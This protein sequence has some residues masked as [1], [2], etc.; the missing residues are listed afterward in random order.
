MKDS[1]SQVD[2][3][4]HKYEREW[5]AWPVKDDRPR[6]RWTSLSNE[7]ITI[8]GLT[9][10]EREAF[11]AFL[12]GASYIRCVDG[13]LHAYHSWLP[14]PNAVHDPICGPHWEATA[15]PKQFGGIPASEG[16]H[17]PGLI[18]TGLE[19]G[20]QK[21]VEAC[22]FVCLRSRRALDGKYWEQWVLHFMDAAKGPLEQH[23]REHAKLSW[24]EK[25][26]EA[27]RFLAIDLRVRFGSLDITIQRWALACP[28]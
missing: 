24:H 4:E 20:M 16:W 5:L 21:L 23:M 15:E 10:K 18:L 25:A 28:D 8:T 27:C 22:G 3:L 12:A 19:A 6:I 26:E 11:E 17:S 2:V 1:K 7:Q 9:K 14:L 13:R